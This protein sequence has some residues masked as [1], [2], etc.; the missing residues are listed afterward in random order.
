MSIITALRAIVA[1][2]STH[3]DVRLSRK[4]IISLLEVVDREPVAYVDKDQPNSV[5][6]CPG[7]PEAL[8]D[9]SKLYAATAPV[10]QGDRSR[11]PGTP[12]FWLRAA[13]D[14]KA[15]VW[16]QDQR[17]MAEESLKVAPAPVVCLHE[18]FETGDICAP[19]EIL[20]R[21]GEVVLALCK[22]CGKAES[23]LSGK[24]EE[25]K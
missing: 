23:E 13:L 17:E 8:P 20:D 4:D 18:L 22:K 7:Y 21:N 11:D 24:T 14:C 10:A 16:D 1:P 3:H 9:I 2:G 25:Q 5:A 15:F 19:R 12:E 6:W